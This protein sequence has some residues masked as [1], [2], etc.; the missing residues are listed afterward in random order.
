MQA[1]LNIKID[2]V[3]QK[4]LGIIRDLLS[5]DVEIVIKKERL[6]LEEYDARLPLDAVMEEFKGA[7]YSDAFVHDVREGFETSTVYPSHN[8]H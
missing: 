5:K 1:M 2:E 4:L 6:K 7:G 3:D 8:E